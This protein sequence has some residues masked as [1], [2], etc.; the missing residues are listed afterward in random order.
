MTLQGTRARFGGTC[1]TFQTLICSHQ[2]PRGC[3]AFACDGWPDD[4]AK[5]LLI[6]PSSSSS[7][8]K[9]IGCGTDKH[10]A[11]SSGEQLFCTCLYHSVSERHQHSRLLPKNLAPVQAPECRCDFNHT[12][13]G[14]E[15]G[16]P[17]RDLLVLVSLCQL[18]PCAPTFQSALWK[19]RFAVKRG[20]ILACLGY[21]WWAT[22]QVLLAA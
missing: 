20:A 2:R 17:L 12:G 9:R 14:S 7:K 15:P 13:G 8:R 10:R 16:D 6:S 4:D 19:H 21:V 18:D 1:V 5:L 22:H 3:P 11:S